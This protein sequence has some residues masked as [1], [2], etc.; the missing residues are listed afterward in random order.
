MFSVFVKCFNALCSFSCLLLFLCLF[1]FFVGRLCMLFVSCLCV[2]FFF[3][4]LRVHLWLRV[5]FEVSF[6]C[7]GMFF[8]NQSLLCSGPSGC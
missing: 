7:F 6:C 8:H 3:V 5:C 2:R 1:S 4:R